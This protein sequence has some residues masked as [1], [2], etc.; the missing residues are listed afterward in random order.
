MKNNTKALTDPMKLKYNQYSL[1]WNVSIDC[2]SYGSSAIG[3]WIVCLHIFTK[4]AIQ[5]SRIQQICLL[6]VA[7]TRSVD[8]RR[9][10]T[11]DWHSNGSGKRI[12]CACVT[13]QMGRLCH[14]QVVT[15][16]WLTISKQRVDISPICKARRH[17][18][19]ESLVHLLWMLDCIRKRMVVG[20]KC[21]SSGLLSSLSEQ[22]RRCSE[23]RRRHH[24]WSG[25]TGRFVDLLFG[26][27]WK[28]GA[29]FFLSVI[30]KWH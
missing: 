14:S 19:G 23:S 22:A 2:T 13:K 5:Q 15:V 29:V 16:Q 24:A 1:N 30:T 21:V 10:Y 11:Q 17:G 3:P 28:G 18:I 6:V 20:R 27:K 8:G 12:G 7:K 26:Q 9:V 4:Q 25:C